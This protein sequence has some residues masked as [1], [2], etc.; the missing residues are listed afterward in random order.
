MRVRHERLQADILCKK[1]TIDDMNREIFAHRKH[2]ANLQT[3]LV[4]RNKQ[5]Q[6]MMS[7]IEALYASRSWR[8]TAPLRAARR[9]FSKVTSPSRSVG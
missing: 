2:A 5:N 3:L 9:F 1:A 8:M 4:D 6:E 7:R